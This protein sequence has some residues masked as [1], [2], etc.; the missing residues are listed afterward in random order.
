[1]AYGR[2]NDDAIDDVTWPSRVK[3]VIPI[4]LRP[5]ISKTARDRVSVL[6]GHHLP[7]NPLKAVKKIHLAYICTLWAPSSF[8]IY[9]FAHVKRTCSNR[10]KSRNKSPWSPV[11]TNL[12]HNEI[13]RQWFRV[14]S[15]RS[16]IFCLYHVFQRVNYFIIHLF[17]K[18]STISCYD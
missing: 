5:V 1:M 15:N 12:K 14:D 13:D 10:N 16:F 18:I 3:V 2:S 17:H 7:P 9:L 8:F 4:S 11:F 6:T